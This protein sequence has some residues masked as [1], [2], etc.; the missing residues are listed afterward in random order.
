[1]HPTMSWARW[2]ERVFGVEIERCARC[3]VTLAIIASIGEPAL[4]AKILSH[5]GRTAPERYP[6]APAVY[7]GEPT[8]RARRGSVIVTGT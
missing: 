7:P 5:L 8:G 3:Q 4:I 6:A 1:M 2:L